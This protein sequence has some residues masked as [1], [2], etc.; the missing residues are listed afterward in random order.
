MFGDWIKKS[1][2]GLSGLFGGGNN[3]NQQAQVDAQRQADLAAQRQREEEERKRREEAAAEAR[4]R[5]EEQEQANPLRVP[6][7]PT[8]L[9]VNQNRVVQP[10]VEQS[11]VQKLKDGFLEEARLKS[12]SN[13]F[14]N[15]LSGG[16]NERLAQN[17]A[18]NMAIA[19]M[20][21][22]NNSNQ[23]KFDLYLDLLL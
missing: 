6:T 12:G 14:G 7:T 3:N 8:S 15:F 18:T 5:A 11:E 23:N 2:G 1:V 17:D 16:N 9:N 13:F 19:E 20:N 21:R 4:R 22:R 10:Q